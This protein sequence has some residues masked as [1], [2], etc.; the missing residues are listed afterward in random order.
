MEDLKRLILNATENGLLVF[1][2]LYPQCSTKKPFLSPFYGDTT[3]S[4]SLYKKELGIYLFKDFGNPND[5]GDCFW[6]YGRFKN[7]D[8]TDTT[9][10][11]EIIQL[12]ATEYLYLTQKSVSLPIKKSAT[13]PTEIARIPSVK[14]TINY[15]IRPFRKD[16]L[17]FWE[18]Y[19]IDCITLS[20]FHVRCVEKMDS[21]SRRGNP[22]SYTNK[23]NEPIFAYLHES[24]TKFYLPKSNLRFLSTGDKPENFIFGFEQLPIRGDI[25]F[26]TG[27][28]KDVMSLYSKGFSAI[29]FNSE[30][31]NIPQKTIDNLKYRFKHLVLL[32]DCDETGIRSMNKIVSE[33]KGLQLKQI[34][35]PLKG[36]KSE[37]DISD[38]FR[39]GFDKEVLLELFQQE[40]NKIYQNTNTLLK[41]IMLDFTNPPIEPESLIRIQNTSIASEGNIVCITGTEGS[42]KT[43]FIGGLVAGAILE[44]VT[45]HDTL[46]T[47]ILPNSNGKCVL[48]FDT[49][50]SEYQF[51]KN[52][53]YILERVDYKLPPP[54][55]KTIS[56][57]GIK[58]IER[59]K[60]ILEVMDSFYFKF[61]GI[62]MVV[63]DG[64]A[65]LLKS[66]NDE[67]SSVELV[68]ELFR[69]AAIYNTVIVGVLHLSPSG[70]KL[71]GHLGSELQRKSS[72]ILHVEKDESEEC[73]IVKALKVRD[74]SPFDVPSIKFQWDED[75]DRHKFIGYKNKRETN[76]EKLEDLMKT[77]RSEYENQDT[78]KHSDIVKL[79]ESSLNVR[80]RTARKYISLLISGGFLV[81]SPQFPSVLRLK[82]VE[83][84]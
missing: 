69:L 14:Q 42:G 50:Q 55:F 83:S 81:K 66:V 35:L 60:I 71:R 22:W 23:P 75:L 11:K 2:S 21:I 37:K 10:F 44:K 15:S 54:F 30:T 64:V 4:C 6:F 70:F 12:M 48:I 25:L 36:T 78:F 59:L 17:L 57:V 77:I 5:F 73:S 56:L 27:G 41:S 33:Y 47:K 9:D 58:R 40:L 1:T 8:C 26:I 49:E 51:Y 39:L 46:G 28:E 79:V 13:I 18:Q 20:Q 82:E 19:G 67:E 74:G 65:D 34:V 7:L 3:P 52:V 31:A 24:F 72:G 61:G 80:D 76:T 45:E 53:S 43:N 84:L 16:E 29:S 63:I 68:E 32:Y 38:F 62:H